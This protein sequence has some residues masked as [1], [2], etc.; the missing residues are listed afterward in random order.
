MDLIDRYLVAV[1]RHLPARL[2][3]DVV[4]ELTDNLRSEAEAQ[5]QEAGR[6]LTSEEQAALLKRHGH[7][8]LMASRYLPQQHL[9]GPA[10]YPYYRQAITVVVFW[11]VLPITLA[12][13]AI[14][15][16]NSGDFGHFVSRVI[17]ALWNGS[18]YAVGMTTIVFAVLEHERVRFTAIDNWEPLKL[19]EL[20]PGRLV[21][22]SETIPSLIAMLAFL[23]WW[24]GLVQT[25]ELTQ[26]GSID[27]RFVATPIWSQL[28]YPVLLAV[29]GG[30]AIGFVDM[31]HPWRTRVTSMADIV[32]NLVIAGVAVALVRAGWFVEVMGDPQ[33]ADRLT[34]ANQWINTSIS[35][36]LTVV[37]AIALFDVVNELWKISRNGAAKNARTVVA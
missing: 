13:A 7:P 31:V 3:D 5:E 23:V 33:H 21:P 10:I 27:A 16:I 32:V 19:P 24:V 29:A 26:Y 28:Y 25:P 4:Q 2:Q 11:I 20:R 1:R 9:I 15:G 35:W 18:L 22:R 12:G 8:W 37:A 6:G 36:G 14:A 34:R 30:V 17:G